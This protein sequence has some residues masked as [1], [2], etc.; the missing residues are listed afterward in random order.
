MIDAEP[1]DHEIGGFNRQSAGKATRRIVLA[2][3]VFATLWILLSD[4]VVAAYVS[5]SSEFAVFSAL[6]GMFFV[7][8]TSIFL[9]F[10]VRRYV[11]RLALIA[12]Q[13]RKS[14]RYLNNIINTVGDPVFVKDNQSRLLMANDAFC[15]LFAS[16]RE[17]L[18]GNTLAEDVDPSERDYFLRIDRQV[19]GD[20]CEVATEETLTFR[21]QSP[22][23]LLTGK[24]RYTDAAGIHFL[25]GVIR[26]ITQRKEAENRLQLAASVFTHAR[27][28]ITITD[29]NGTIIDVNDPTGCCSATACNMPLH[30]VNAGVRPSLWSTSIWTTSKPSTTPMAT[31]RVMLC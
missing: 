18:I 28:G 3:A 25:V 29:A 26:D 17:D 2:Y 19:I 12:E 9:A 13:F 1:S 22:R 7:A 14:V 15:A 5:D 4:Q 21:G 31:R 10:V 27:E 11:G 20:G 6:K 8:I 23:T 30:T 16:A 24:T